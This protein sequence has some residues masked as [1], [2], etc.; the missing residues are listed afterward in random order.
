M[1][2]RFTLKDGG[3]AAH[4]ATKNLPYANRDEASLLPKIFY[5][6]PLSKMKNKHRYLKNQ[7]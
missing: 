1:A 5:R 6:C 3:S 7:P 4:V 2:Y